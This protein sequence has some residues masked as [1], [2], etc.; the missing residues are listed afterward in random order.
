M[1]PYS[2]FDE[3]PITITGWRHHLKLMEFDE[4]QITEFIEPIKIDL[5][6]SSIQRKL[7]CTEIKIL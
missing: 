3:Y 4:E 6:L 1:T 2:A 5:T 7:E